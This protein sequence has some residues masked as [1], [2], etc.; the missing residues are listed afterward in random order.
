MTS[1]AR[2]PS[3]GVR[4]TLRCPP[5]SCGVTGAPPAYRTELL[6]SPAEIGQTAGTFSGYQC[7]ET[8]AHQR[9]LLLDAGELGC[10]PQGGIINIERRSH[11]HQYAPLMHTSQSLVSAS[12]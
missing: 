12:R 11:V 9:G 6:F 10:L 1:V 7:L 8:Q 3:A 5:E 4:S 2:S